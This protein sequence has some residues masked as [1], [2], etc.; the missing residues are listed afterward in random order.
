MVLTDPDYRRRGLATSLM[1][2]AIA[3]LESRG[4]S[5][6]LDATPAGE[7]VYG[8]LGFSG[9]ILLSRY[10]LQAGLTQEQVLDA[11]YIL[12]PIQ[13]AEI[14]ALSTLCQ[15]R[16]GWLREA[17]LAYLQQQGPGLAWKAVGSDQ[18]P[19]GIIFGRPGSLATHLGPLIA[20]DVTIARE[21]LQVAMAS[22]PGPFLIDAFAHQKNWTGWLEGYGFIRERGF[23]RLIK[24][25][26]PLPK[27]EVLSRHFASAG[28]EMG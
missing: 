22:L 19:R 11:G 16:S 21:L 23:R 7:A 15:D 14:G 5:P 12:E 6:C 4:A 26:R 9:D 27:M 3:W 24:G 20:E 1:S 13:A 28:P 18:T 2:E 17:L 10:V 25:P 8:H